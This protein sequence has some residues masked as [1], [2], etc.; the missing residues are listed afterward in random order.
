MTATPDR[1]TIAQ[2]DFGQPL[3]N[4][5][6]RLADYGR[7][8][9]LS[10]TLDFDTRVLSLEPPGAGWTEEAK[11]GHLA[12]QERVRQGL[13]QEYGA[14]DLEVKIQNF[15]DIG[16]KPFSV[17]AYHNHFFDQVRRSFVMGA[18][19]P[20]LVGACA[21]GERILNHLV[22]DLRQ[23]YSHTPE[24]K[25]VY[26]KASFDDWAVA[27][28]TLLAWGILLPN[29]VTEFQ[30]LK[31]LRHGSIHFN[32]GTYSTLRADALAAVL[33]IREIIDQQFTAF[34]LRPWFI[35]GT[36][37]HIFIRRDWE[38]NPFVKTFYLPTCPFV[39]PHFA[40]SFEGGLKY[41]D[42]PDYGDG[43]WTDDEFAQAFNTRRPEDI[44]GMQAVQEPAP[45][46]EH[47]G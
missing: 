14:R 21:L 20:A 45:P 39:G 32:V 23:Y 22:L 19:Y 28:D 5:K 11:A 9:H 35:K 27:I 26:R 46:V 43:V 3:E 29:A 37:G 6:P 7:R 2:V 33:H 34:G 44:V 36:L 10:Y 15:I 16:T 1:F 31:T 25:R 38:D 4:W 17:L 18:Y 12:N 30:A 13:A 42:H 8:R 40:I 41:H 24:Y 47:D